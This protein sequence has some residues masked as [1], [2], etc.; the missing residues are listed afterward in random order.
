MLEH[1][2]NPKKML[3]ERS[4]KVTYNI[5]LTKKKHSQKALGS[6]NWPKNLSLQVNV[7]KTFFKS[8]E[9]VFVKLSAGEPEANVS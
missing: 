2:W 8:W 3:P 1:S 5:P 6:Q 9:K 4:G 7:R